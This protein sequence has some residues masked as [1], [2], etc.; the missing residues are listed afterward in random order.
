MV[1]YTEST[2]NNIIRSFKGRIFFEVKVR[3][4]TGAERGSTIVGG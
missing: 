1:L 4:R 2:G 3:G